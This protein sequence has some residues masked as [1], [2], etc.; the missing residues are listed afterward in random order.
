MK[1]LVFT[2]GLCLVATVSF[3]QKKAVSEALKLAKDA[4][5]NFTEAKSL[6]SGALENAETKNDAKT[7]Y[8]AGQIESLQFDSENTKE[9]LGQVPNDAI[10]YSA[11]I[12]VYPFFL[13]SYELDN[14]PDA[15]GKVKPKHTKDI[16]AMQGVFKVAVE[17]CGIT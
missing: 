15:K 14:L 16:K 9:I 13:K 1:K 8:I 6:I 7:W 11:L 2:L 3:G 10:K 17:I 4:K 5:P 12:K